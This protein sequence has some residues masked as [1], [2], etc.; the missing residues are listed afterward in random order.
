MAGRVILTDEW[1]YDRRAAV[2]DQGRLIA[3]FNDNAFDDTPRP[4]AVVAVRVARVF[5][6]R[7]RISAD[8]DGIPASLRLGR[9]QAPSPGQV[10][11]ATV[12]AEPREGKP[13]QLR[14]GYFIEHRWFLA[15]S[16][17]GGLRLSQRLRQGGFTPPGGLEP[18][19]CQITLRLGAASAPPDTLMEEIRIAEDRI[20]AIKAMPA[21]KPGVIDNGPDAITTAR[22][23]F[24]D[25]EPVPGDDSTA[26]LQAGVDEQLEAAL[27]PRV[28]LGG[29]GILHVSTPPG[30]AVFD[31]DSG[32]GDMTLRALAAAMVPAIARALV[33]RRIS[34]P[35]VADFPRLNPAD[36]K[37][38]GASMVEAVEHDPLRPQCHGFE[39]G[40]L[41]TMTR[42]W[43]WRPLADLMAGDDR[44]L[45][46]D[47][48]RLARAA[49]GGHDMA[50]AI[51]VPASVL[52][53]LEGEGAAA[54]LA[55][56]K[57]LAISPRFLSDEGISRPVRDET[58]RS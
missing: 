40:G 17:A 32:D 45:G 22:Q 10:I 44:R 38:I 29:G 24:P 46:L 54:R 16:T 36:R 15:D 3:F 18:S 27:R 14:Q 47:A 1:A 12:T 57:S 50:P 52:A 41:Y 56:L 28:D 26:W 31:G 34:G 33:L 49:A 13:L 39:P 5:P 6:D 53:W 20:R 37:A 30:A 58:A 25:A 2:L 19:S 8:L 7:D 35:V 4:G 42:P 55:A 48:L 43:R 9:R 23:A 51:R 21:L 11:L